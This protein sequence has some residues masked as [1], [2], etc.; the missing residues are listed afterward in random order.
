MVHA[1]HYHAVQCPPTETEIRKQQADQKVLSRAEELLLEQ[2][3]EAKAMAQM[4][5]ACKCVT[6]RDAQLAER[7]YMMLEEE[8]ENRRLDVMIEQERLK[9]LDNYAERERQRKEER[10]HGAKV[11]TALHTWPAS[12]ARR[13]AE[14]GSSSL[15]RSWEHTATVQRSGSAAR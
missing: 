12:A 9:A 2:Q 4:V 15:C 10:M 14:F 13:T 3:D 8:A 5:N 11:Q 1:S 6:I 7:K